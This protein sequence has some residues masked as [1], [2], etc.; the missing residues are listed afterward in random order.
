[1]E[2]ENEP[3]FHAAVR[4]AL[5][6]LQSSASC[7]HFLPKKNVFRCR[8][9][10]ILLTCKYAHKDF[11][12]SRTDCSRLNKQGLTPRVCLEWDYNGAVS[13]HILSATFTTA[14]ATVEHQA[15][16]WRWT[17]VHDITHRSYPVC[18]WGGCVEMQWA[19]LMSCFGRGLRWSSWICEEK[20]ISMQDALP[21]S[22]SDIFCSL[23][24]TK[25]SAQ[26]TRALALSRLYYI[27][28]GQPAPV[29]M[30]AK[31]DTE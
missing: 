16:W 28:T 31:H 25:S 23:G 17:H 20:E 24:M 10:I 1:M 21:W 12:G 14:A 29:S 18:T 11:W 3:H 19:A 4:V 30:I 26:T 2:F 7:H 5:R 13:F 8:G 27:H 6:V 22:P 9:Y 15:E